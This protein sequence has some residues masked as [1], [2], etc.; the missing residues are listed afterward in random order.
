VTVRAAAGALEEEAYSSDDEWTDAKEGDPL[1]PRSS[2]D[3]PLSPK[4]QTRRT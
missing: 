2:I 3:T 4:R 1:T